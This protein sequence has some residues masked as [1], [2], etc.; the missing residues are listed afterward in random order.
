VT[1]P[2]VVTGPLKT[3]KKG[4]DLDGANKRRATGRAD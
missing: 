4:K 3:V 2:S 1:E